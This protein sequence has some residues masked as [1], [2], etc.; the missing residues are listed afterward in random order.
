[1][2]FLQS[3]PALVG[4]APRVLILG[5]MPGTASLL[6]GQYYAHRQNRFWPLMG[7]LVGASP[8][9]PYPARCE[10]LTG[11]GI[12]LW[13][14]LARCQREGSLD[15]AIRDDTAQANDFASLLVSLPTIRTVLFNG[16][17]AESSF[18]RFVAPTLDL[19]GLAYR[20]LPSTSPANASQGTDY[21][22][23]TW[24]DALQAGG[25]AT[26]I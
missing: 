18:L 15:S 6:A 16:T 17:K 4:R 7:E 13:D 19:P 2:P 24:R 26:L 8:G 3:F 14:V 1:M 22:R 23:A 11:S 5:S 20:R 21:K 9:L 25:I 12:A 10:R